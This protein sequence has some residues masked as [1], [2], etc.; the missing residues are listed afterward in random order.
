MSKPLSNDPN[1]LGGAHPGTKTSQ[2]IENSISFTV[3]SNRSLTDTA[4]DIARA[5]EWS[6]TSLSD[7]SSSSNY[8]TSS[9]VLHLANGALSISPGLGQLIL[10]DRTNE[11]KKGNF[12]ISDQDSTLYSNA[13]STT[14]GTLDISTADGYQAN[15]LDSML[16]STN[17]SPVKSWIRTLFP[18]NI[19]DLIKLTIIEAIQMA[20]IKALDD[21][22]GKNSS[23]NSARKQT[24]DMSLMIQ[25]NQEIEDEIL[26]EFFE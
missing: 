4:R 11:P 17:F 25:D 6:L 18:F 23:E 19:K 9:D 7:P 1:A 3:S 5:A 26:E 21:H 15:P 20:L 24:E 13:S 2:E 8:A 10:G 16:P 22:L 12:E 14:L